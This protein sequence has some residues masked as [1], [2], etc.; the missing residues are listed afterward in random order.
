MNTDEINEELAVMQLSGLE[1]LFSNNEIKGL[2]D[3]KNMIKVNIE[4]QI[5]SSDC[6]ALVNTLEN[7]DIDDFEKI[8]QIDEILFAMK[9]IKEIRTASV[10]SGIQL[11]KCVSEFM[12]ENKIFNQYQNAIKEKN[13][14]GIF[15]V[16][17][18]ICCNAL[19]IKKEKSMTMLLYGFTVSVVG[20][21]LR[22]G[23]IQHLEGQKIIHEIK[24]IIIQAI[25]KN[26][27]KSIFDMWQFTPQLDIV[28]MSHEKMDSK[29]FIT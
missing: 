5:G 29:M 13:A 6:V 1:F 23:L 28:Q 7:A 17:F 4:Q 27:N 3:I 20:A 12:K 9:S 22:L 10:N 14:Y 8:I 26:I 24:P 11:I 16:A 21:A 18:A 2:E 25:E 15:P 19:N